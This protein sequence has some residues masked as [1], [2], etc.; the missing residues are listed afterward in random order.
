[1]V[2]LTM[3]RMRRSRTTGSSSASAS[4][5]SLVALLTLCGCGKGAEPKQPSVAKTSD[6]AGKDKSRGVATPP[7]P[8]MTDPVPLWEHGRSERNIDAATSGRNREL[9]YDLGEVWTPY[10]FSEGEPA[11]P[12]K[13]VSSAYRPTYL[14]LAR[15]EFP[16]DLHGERAKD[17]KYLELYGILPTL[18]VVRARMRATAKLSCTKDLDLAPLQSFDGV[19]TYTSNPVARRDVKTYAYVKAHTLDIMQ[20][21]GVATPEE[22]DTTGLSNRDRDSVTRYLAMTPA[23]LAI[24][25]LQQR[26]KCEGYYAGKGKYL[27]GVIDWATHEALAEFERRHRVYSWGFIGKDSQVPLRMPPMEAER[28]AVLRVL[29]ERAMHTAGVIEDGSTS[30]LANGTPRTFIGNDGQA[31]PIPNI[32]GSLREDL[33]DAFGLQ[34]PDST[35]AWLESLGELPKGQHRYVAIRMVPLPE[36][37]SAEMQLTLDY[38]RGDVWY[39][40][41]FNDQGQEIPQPVQ[42]RPQV[43]VSTYYNGKKI[44]LARYG[45]TIGGWRTELVN[46]VS[47]WKYKD[48][49]VGPRAWEEII[50]GPVWLP[51]EGTPPESLL[52]RNPKRKLPSD[53]EYL[54]NYHETGPSYAS[55]YGLVAAYHR[56]FF[57]KADGTVLLGRDEGIRT[58]GSV[59]YMS[60]MRRHSHGCHR[61][62]NHIAMRLMSFVLAH[63]PHDRMGQ[64]PASFKKPLVY[65]DLAYLVDIKQGGYVF[66]LKTPLFVNVEEGR[67]RG[68]IKWPITIPIPKYDANVAA[69]VMPDGSTVRVRG[70]QLIALTPPTIAPAPVDGSSAQLSPAASTEGSSRIAVPVAPE[71]IVRASVRPAPGNAPAQH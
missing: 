62:H 6:K 55:A 1:M 67:I 57:R 52:V 45:T 51:P 43:T 66:K 9:I 7:P 10:L 48:S 21:Q 5:L 39:D 16:D 11:V 24:E 56:T 70:N 41:P 68:Q 40:F 37:Y 42:R 59:D 58:H 49:P 20:Q 32:A 65:K 50:A 38:D 15:G 2:M 53:P 44:P 61:L 3:S 54:V 14:A 25:A 19:A 22:I 18:H 69:Y 33:I 46:G 29:V 71:R 12:G 4:W 64:E 36:Y 17:D 30:T 13:A 34:T 26:L 47:M 31:H 35:L 23:R 60:I 8:P 63:R 28:E 27:K